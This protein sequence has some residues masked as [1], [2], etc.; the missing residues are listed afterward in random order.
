MPYHIAVSG[1][2]PESADLGVRV[3]FKINFPD[4]FGSEPFQILLPITDK[5]ILSQFS[6]LGVCLHSQ[7]PCHD[8]APSFEFN[9]LQVLKKLEMTSCTADL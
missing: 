9:P 6:S 8:F 7:Q 5:V 4:S 3:H 2:Y 1:R